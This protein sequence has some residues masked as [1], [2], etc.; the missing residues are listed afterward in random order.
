MAKAKTKSDRIRKLLDAGKTVTEV[1]KIVKTSPSLV[2]AVRAKMREERGERGEV[3]SLPPKQAPNLVG[4]S[5]IPTLRNRVTP[6]P[7]LTFWQRVIKWFK[8]D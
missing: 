8:G 1:C 7:K 4:D 6:P 5:G 2:Y 3:K